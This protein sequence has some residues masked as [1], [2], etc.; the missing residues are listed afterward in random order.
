MKKFI[1][2]FLLSF[3]NIKAAKIY[4]NASA[5]GANNGLSWSNAYTNLQTAISNSIYGD[6]IWVAAGT[7][8]A[9]ST[10]DRTISFNMKNGVNFYGGFNGTETSP[11]QRDINQNPTTLS[12]DIGALGDNSDNTNTV[13]KIISIT[14]GI[15]VD[16]F[17]IISGRTGSGSA[18]VALNNNT[19]I[20]NIQNCFFYDNFGSAAGAMFLAYQGN[21]TVNVSN[22]DFVSNISVNGAV[23][24]DN[25]NHNLNINNCRFKGSVAG[26]KA[27]MVFMGGNLIID[28]CVVT[29]NTSTQSDLFYINANG[30]AKISNTLIAGNSFNEA[31]I[32]FYSSNPVSQILEN[33]TI[34]HNKK[35]FLTNT[36]DAA[37]FSVNGTVKVYNSIIYGNTN[38]SNNNQIDAGNTVS[39]SIIENGYSTG[40]NI[41][42]AAPL[43]VN[44]GNL[45]LAPFDCTVY[46]YKVASNS[47]A[48]NSGN[49]VFVTQTQDLAGNTRVFGSTVDRGAYESTSNLNLLEIRAD[50]K[51]LFYNFKDETLYLKNNNNVS[52][53]IYDLTGK[54]VMKKSF[55]NQLLLHHLK[56]G[57]YFVKLAN[58]SESLKIVKR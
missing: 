3:L 23:F 17:R 19:G 55:T 57:V 53:V 21:Y 32:A 24:T 52:V 27:V 14:S 34:V 47:P 10:T 6:E 37:V 36:A 35:T 12:G 41:L 7:Y 15:T 28:R 9:T 39:H 26:G 2:F 8:K 33:V 31:G 40:I 20:I 25:A 45:S 51:T 18:G 13:L 16:G 11:N 46:D 38:S 48:I 5:T 29:N 42:N 50:V 30:S 1:F 49:N 4:V 54:I 44:P 43:F 22:C 56:T 58:T